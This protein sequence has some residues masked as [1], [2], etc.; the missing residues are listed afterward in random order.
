MRKK[1]LIIIGVIVAI[2]IAIWALIRD[3]YL[4]EE[5]TSLT[6]AV[7]KILPLPAA[8]INNRSIVSLSDLRQNLLATKQFYEDQDFA[9]IGVRIDFTTEDGRKKLKLWR[10]TILDKL[11]EDEIVMLLSERVGIQ[12]TDAQARARVNQ[13][14]NRHIRGNEVKDNIK[15]LWGFDLDDFTKYIVKPQLYREELALH[16]MENQ[17]YS[18]LKQRAL[19]A[20]SALSQGVDFATVARQYSDAIDAA[21]E[22][23]GE[24][25]WFTREELSLPVAKSVFEETPVGS[26][27]NVIGLPLNEVVTSLLRLKAITV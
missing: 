7:E 17:D 10:R 5:P 3:A 25:R 14:L 12:I 13:E 19:E 4:S 18:P 11:I 1:Y 22:N 15:R 20:K 9:S 21:L 16:V 24:A 6:L 27:T 2:I 26:Y 8:T 23:G